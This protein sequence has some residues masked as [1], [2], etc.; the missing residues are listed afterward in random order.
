MDLRTIEL[1]PIAAA[2]A[3]KTEGLGFF[4][5]VF[6]VGIVLIV[7]GILI[8]LVRQGLNQR[9]FKSPFT[10]AGEQMYL[11]IES[12]CVDRKGVG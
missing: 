12:M 6:Y 5:L 8:W 4:G 7:M 9:I 11:F 2:E 10:Q 3:G 1:L